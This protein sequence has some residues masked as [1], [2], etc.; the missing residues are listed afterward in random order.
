M[1]LN[2]D[3]IIIGS[4]PSGIAAATELK[5]Q[6]INNIVVLERE[7]QA[8]GVP[9]HCQHPTFG[10]LSFKR[11]MKGGA[12]VQKILALSAGVPVMTNTTVV[13]IRPEGK[14]LVSCDKGLVEMQ[15]K[16]V[17]IA[18]GARETP[19]HPRLVSGLRPQGV[20]TTGALQQFIYLNRQKPCRNPVIIG[21]EIVSFSAIWTLR[22]AGIKAKAMIESQPRIT[23]NRP[24][25]LFPALMGVPLHLNSKLVEIG[26]LNRVEYVVIERNGQNERI[27]C[28]A[29]IF[30]GEFTGE[31][32]LIRKS[33]LDFIA[34]TGCPVVDTN[35]RCSDAAYYALGNM[36]HPA[37]MGDQCYLEGKVI[38]EV[39]ARDL[40]KENESA[41]HRITIQHDNHILFTAPG[42]VDKTAANSQF[43]LNIR[44]KQ[45]IS[46]QVTVKAG[47]T[48]LYQGNHR[49]MPGRRVMLKNVNAELIPLNAT[50]IS[51]SIV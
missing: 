51:V 48:I 22:N 9:R 3:A 28:D 21:S 13:E 15:A 31:N 11:P 16:R 44:V 12:F 14:L 4:G 33:H 38:G 45:A 49:C 39:V 40:H 25:S 27:E 30:T 5:Q 29:V 34:N 1:R 37:D 17:L 32:T 18:T 47:S 26:G 24:L 35:G 20:L 41:S 50:E 7:S 43:D 42:C 46:G 6:G 19:R 8:G 10:L 23:A 36:L 2:Y